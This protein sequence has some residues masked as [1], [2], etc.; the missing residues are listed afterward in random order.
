MSRCQ[1]GENL[2]HTSIM[3]HGSSHAAM[4]T[5]AL[6]GREQLI[7]CNL[8]TPYGNIDLGQYWISEYLVA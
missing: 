6:Q 2:L 4:R 3:E 1:E 5:C 8:M 7:R